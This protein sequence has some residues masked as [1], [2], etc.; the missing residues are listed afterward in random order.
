ML[1]ISYRPAESAPI[2][3]ARFALDPCLQPTDAEMM[4]EAHRAYSRG[5][6]TTDAEMMAAA[7]RTLDRSLL[8]APAIREALIAPVPPPKHYTPEQQERRMRS[9]RKCHLPS[10][11]Q[12]PRHA[13]PED[14]GAY[15][16][17]MSARLDN[18]PNLTDGARRRQSEPIPRS[19]SDP[20]C[21]QVSPGADLAVFTIR[22]G[23]RTMAGIGR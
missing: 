7:R 11:Y 22:G 13:P 8:Q 2:P 1:P 9:L 19:L 23:S 15:V 6:M 3:N 18:D 17:V 4:A 10:L 21:R 20:A 5:E 14:T 12:R 16:P